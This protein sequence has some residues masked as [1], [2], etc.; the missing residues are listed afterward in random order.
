MLFR[1]R[2]SILLRWLTSL[3]HLWQI[4]TYEN[5]NYFSSSII[6]N[7]WIL[8]G[9]LRPMILPS[10][11]L[12][13]NWVILV[14]ALFLLLSLFPCFSPLKLITLFDFQLSVKSQQTSAD[15]VD[16]G[17]VVSQGKFSN[18]IYE[19]LLTVRS[20]FHKDSMYM[21]SWL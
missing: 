9:F 19:F 11:F 6:W 20:F 17:D 12:I 5:L 3:A 1:M 16:Q 4:Y 2:R 13:L 15:I 10:S 8:W 14:A 18:A 21:Y 7:Y